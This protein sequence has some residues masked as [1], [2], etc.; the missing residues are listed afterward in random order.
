MPANQLLGERQPLL[1]DMTSSDKSN[2]GVTSAVER[3]STSDSS[4]D[5]IQSNGGF[6]E[7]IS[8]GG[9]VE[10]D[11][12]NLKAPADS[13]E[14]LPADLLAIPKIVRDTV[15]LEDD[16]NTPVVTFRYFVLAVIFILPGAFID[17]MNSYRTT[18]AAYS[19]F[20]VQI[21]SHWAGKWLAKVLPH[22]EISV[23]GR[24][25]FNLNPGP[26]SI[27]ETALVTITA[28]SGATGSLGTSGISLAEIYYGEKVHPAVAIF[29]MWAIVFTGYAF[30]ALARNMLLF[31]PQFIWPQALMQTNLLQS[32]AKS[33]GDS[34]VASK[35]MKVFFCALLGLTV[36]QFFPEFIFPFVSSLAFLCWVAPHNATANFIGSGLGGMGFLNLTL[37]WSNIT[38]QIM[39]YPYF[40]QVIQFVAF[41]FGAWILIPAAKWGNLSGFKHGLMS[42]GLFTSAGDKYPASKLLTPQLTL[43]ETAYAEFGPVHIG[44]QR[45]WNNFFDYAAYVSGIVWLVVFGHKQLTDSI[46]KL[47]NTYKVAKLEGNNSKKSSINAQYTDRL[48]VM[49]TNYEQVPLWWY[50]ALFV[51]TFVILITIFAT[52]HLFI[53]WWAYIVALGFGLL[54]VTP[55]CWLYALTNFQLA[56]GSFNE[57]LYGYMVQNIA[58]RHP[59]GA[60]TYGA[61]AGDVFY[62]AQYMLQDQKIGHYMQLPPKVVFFSQ[63]FGELLGV[64]INYA[65]MRWILNTK[66]DY[67]NGSKVDHLHQ[68]TG[69]SIA[70][71]HTNAV[72][73]VIL[74]PKRTFAQYP[75][76]QYGFLL[77]A[78]VPII[79]GLLHKFSHKTRVGKLRFDLWNTT[80][81]FSSM[82]TFY[83]NVSTGYLSKFIGGTV[84]MFWAYRYKHDLWRRYNYILAAALDTGYNLSLLLIFLFFSA[85]KTVVMPNWWGNNADSVER[86]FAL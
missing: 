13:D 26:W 33:D 71:Y 51:A 56:I 58:A 31:D 45:A 36:W 67:L 53:P 30:A 70:S 35:Q 62:R 43:N 10:G 75:I 78:A 48:N 7:I 74:G 23:F 55:L 14:D 57:L 6:G 73:Y 65:A 11:V 47:R 19:I 86:C 37:D 41:V 17:T 44:A 61:I 8:N 52:G 22:K 77:G 32:Q 27:K 29:Y 16:P 80:V 24:Y 72:Q 40:I 39:I 12:E 54:I 5:P 38:S 82:S 21:A 63:L 4:I 3:Q 46:K 66:M 69:Q 34:K 25:K 84:T 18:S 15:P 50:F 42:N 2:D 81:F 83:G 68:W 49:Q 76:L 64:P 28:S 20:F 59:A 60:T 79:L 85:G 1:T 9:Y